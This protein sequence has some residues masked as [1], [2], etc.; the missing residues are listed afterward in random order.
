MEDPAILLLLQNA[1]RLAIPTSG[2]HYTS[3]PR[4]GALVQP[5]RN[6]AIPNNSHHLIIP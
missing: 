2:D 5:V 6:D 4:K 3:Y 1:A